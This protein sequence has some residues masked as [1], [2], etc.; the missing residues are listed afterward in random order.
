MRLALVLF[1]IWAVAS[2]IWVQYVVGTWHA[3]VDS[4]RAQ[5][6]ALDACE[7]VYPPRT[8][9]YAALYGNSWGVWLANEQSRHPDCAP[10]VGTIALSQFVAMQQPERTA[11]RQH[12]MQGDELA[13]RTVIR[14]GWIPPAA[15]FV[16]VGA[17][18]FALIQLRRG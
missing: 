10:A 18:A 7:P 2:L 3:T 5:I 1:V 8:D 16:I 17:L 6:A 15:L 14:A 9:G 11:L 4:G 12:L 13:T